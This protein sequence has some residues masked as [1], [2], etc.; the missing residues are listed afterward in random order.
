MEQCIASAMRFEVT[1]QKIQ[2]GRQMNESM[3]IPEAEKEPPDQCFESASQHIKTM[4]AA[5]WL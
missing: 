2:T 5:I 4:K 1:L 3:N